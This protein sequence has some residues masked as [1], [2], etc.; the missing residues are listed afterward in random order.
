MSVLATYSESSSSARSATT[1]PPVWNALPGSGQTPV[2]SAALT[3]MTLPFS[4]AKYT[5]SA[6]S[7]GDADTPPL[8]NITSH[9]TAT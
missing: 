5:E 4:P 7:A 3:A 1:G 8:G 6:R 2:R 9:L